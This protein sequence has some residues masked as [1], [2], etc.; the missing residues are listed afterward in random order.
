MAARRKPAPKMRVEVVER[1]TYEVPAI[2]ESEVRSAMELNDTEYL[3]ELLG[4][5]EARCGSSVETVSCKEV[6]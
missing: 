6:K 2:L 3:D 5:I 1:R 4:D